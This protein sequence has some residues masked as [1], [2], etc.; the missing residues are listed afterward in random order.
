MFKCLNIVHIIAHLENIGCPMSVSF[1][2]I[3]PVPSPEQLKLQ[4]QRASDRRRRQQRL[5]DER[6]RQLLDTAW[7]LW[8][9]A[10]AAG[11][12]MRQ[13]AQRAGY[14]AGALYAY[15]PGRDAI[16]SALQ[17]RV[18]QELGEMVNAVKAPRGRRDAGPADASAVVQA[19]SLFIDRSL[20]WWSRLASDAQRLQ[21]VLHGGHGLPETEGQGSG[22]ASILLARLA[23]ALQPC[24]EALHASG[25]PP[26]TAQQVH[27]EVLAYG[28]GLLVL[29]GPD[30]AG[31]RP[32][33]ETRFVQS[34]HRWL[35]VALAAALGVS[36]EAGQGDLFGAT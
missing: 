7:T 13:L 16:L 15:F 26:E 31:A 33:M 8:Q 29:Q 12:N 1:D 11:F 17:Q 21:L 19:R 34:L 10:G 23:E 5:G 36:A 24:L 30:R 35:D 6:R 20:A 14:T 22:S 2:A 28:L 25:L 9:E 27:D 3:V 32:A 4:Q 18:I